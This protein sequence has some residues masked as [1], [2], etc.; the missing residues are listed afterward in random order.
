MKSKISFKKPGKKPMIIG[1]LVLCACAIG[2]GIWYYL[3]HNRSEPVYVYPFQYIGMTEYWGDTMESGGPVTTDNIQTIFLSDT[4]TVTKVCVKE[5]D[6]VKKGDVLLEYDTTLSDLA[7]EKKRLESEKLKLDLED[8]KRE[9]RR[10]KGLRPMVTPQVEEPQQM[11]E[12]PAVDLGYELQESYSISKNKNFDGSTPERA[13]ICWMKPDTPVDSTLLEILRMTAE[14]FQNANL[15][16]GRASAS[17]EGEPA[18]TTTATVPATTE[19]TPT[20][21]ATTEPAT[22]EPATTETTVPETEPPVEHVD[23]TSFYVVFKITQD[24][25]SLGQR[26]V[27]QGMKVKKHNDG[28][29]TF[30]LFDAMALGDHTVPNAGGSTGGDDSWVE[31]PEKPNVDMGSGYTAEQ[32]LQMRKDQEKKIRDLGFQQKMAEADYKIMLAEM[33]DGSIRSELDGKVVSLITPEEAKEQKQPVMKV[34]GGGGFVIEGSVGELNKDLLQIGQE[35]TVNDW[36]NG[37]SY[38]GTVQ[39]IGEFPSNNWSWN[40]NTNPNVT[41]YPF[42]VFVDESADLQAGS[43]A[44]ITFAA[45]AS[46]NGIYLENPF[47]RSEK[48][49]SY[50]YLLGANGKLEKRFVTTGKSLWS[51]YTEILSGITPED[52]IAFPYGKNVKPGVSAVEGDLSNLYS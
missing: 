11:P 41:Y 30:N 13:L 43:Y 18:E 12:P 1:A 38:T 51:S 19:E 9:L 40:G 32:L 49:R 52:K 23:V 20:E 10:L 36:R 27:W 44:N 22:T 50:V 24:N 28:H 4:Q 5:G 29:F 14:E 17:L 16:K 25:L 2:G 33:G 47:I 8:A 31:M 46:Q 21:P 39:S 15:K 35:V 7:L 26:L 6:K 3:G 37:M 45:G 34:S 48:G 42:T